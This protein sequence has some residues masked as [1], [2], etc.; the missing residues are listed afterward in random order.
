[1]LMLLVVLYV[2]V[3]GSIFLVDILTFLIERYSHYHIGRWEC[4]DKWIATVKRKC[5]NW[6]LHTPVLRIKKD[7]R[8]LLIDRIRGKY[9]KKMVQSWQKAGCVLGIIAMH[10]D[11]D[12]LLVVSK[13]KKQIFNE[14]GSWKHIPDRIDYAMLA[15]S[16]LQVEER[17]EQLKKGMDQVIQCIEENVCSDGL[18]S[19][20]AGNQAKRRYVDTLG[21]ICPFLA[22]YGKKY[23]NKKYI[24]MAINQIVQFHKYGTWN[25]LPVHCYETQ[26]NLPIGILGWGRGTGWYTLALTDLYME[27]EEDSDKQLIKTYLVEVAEK[28]LDFEREDG[29]FSSILQ[30][31]SIY[32]SSATVMLGYFYAN[33]GLWFSNNTYLE[34]AK[35]CQKRLMRVTKMNGVIDECQGDTIDVGIFSEKYG[36]MPFVQ[37]MTLR[38]VAVLSKCDEVYSC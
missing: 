2:V 35:R 13:V 31:K 12:V 3:T 37:G 8:Y 38:L 19:Y 10:E 11:S 6:A 32:D 1:M 20:S 23:G 18:V 4:S 21:F 9:G 14:N 26:T 34:V 27:L 36:A 33:C 24:Q 17:P 22:L 30:A 5:I 25:G 7:Y 28:C 16:I 29:G 15:Y